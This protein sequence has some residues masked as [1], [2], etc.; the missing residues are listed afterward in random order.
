MVCLSR[1]IE[2]FAGELEPVVRNRGCV[3]PPWRPPCVCSSSGR[4]ASSTIVYLVAKLRSFSVST[5]YSRPLG[6]TGRSPVKSCPSNPRSDLRRVWTAPSADLSCVAA[7]VTVKPPFFFNSFTIFS[8][9][10]SCSVGVRRSGPVFLGACF[11]N[12]S[13]I[14]AACCACPRKSLS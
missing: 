1:S 11:S 2:P 9:R 6:R 14:F 10:R 13:L 3:R 7:S 4:F 12:M 8:S 5:S